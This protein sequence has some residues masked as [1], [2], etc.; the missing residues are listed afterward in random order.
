MS[1]VS[2]EETKV[3]VVLP[4][5]EICKE[6]QTS[7]TE[8]MSSIEGKTTALLGYFSRLPCDYC[9]CRMSLAEEGKAKKEGIYKISVSEHGRE[10]QDHEL[11]LLL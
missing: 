2:V 3:L 1:T 10:M 5:Q 9:S 8:T 11:P 6:R 7:L 4:V